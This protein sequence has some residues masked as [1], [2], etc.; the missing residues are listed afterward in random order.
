MALAAFQH[1]Q[2]VPHT[3]IRWIKAIAR[4]IDRVSIAKRECLLVDVD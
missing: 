2:C 3:G 1:G 4:E